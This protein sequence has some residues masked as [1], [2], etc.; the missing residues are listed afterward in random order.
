MLSSLYP[1]VRDLID[2]AR[3]QQLTFMAA[4]IAYYAFLSVVPLVIVGFAVATT[5]AGPA[6]AELF[7]ITFGEFLTPEGANVLEEA[8]VQ[9]TGRGGVTLVGLA[10]LL[11]TSLRVFRA[12]DI[13]FSNVYGSNRVKPITEQLRDAIIVL[14]GVGAAVAVTATF[15]ALTLVVDLWIANFITTV[16]L[17]LMLPVVFFPLYYVF[18]PR[19]VTVREALPGAIFTGL[20][21]SVLGQLFSIYTS[22]AGG[23]QLYGVLAGVLLLLVWFYFAGLVLLLGAALN[24]VLGDSIQTERINGLEDA[25]EQTDSDTVN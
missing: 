12:L 16:S 18:P 1:T 15:T 6:V 10:I 20:A 7:L 11:W 25:T 13:A 21:W 17:I 19:R 9:G 24:A 22:V 23:F 4:A 14:V 3:T 8:L 2:V 5:I